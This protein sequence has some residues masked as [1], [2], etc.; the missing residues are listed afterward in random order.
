MGVAVG[1]LV[2]TAV[3]GTGVLVA[4]LSGVG[5]T[6]PRRTSRETGEAA[7]PGIG[8]QPDHACAHWQSPPPHPVALLIAAHCVG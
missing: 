8:H 6:C 4:P 5:T 3:G 2:G 1:P 7:L